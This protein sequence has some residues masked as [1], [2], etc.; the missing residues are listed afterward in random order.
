MPISVTSYSFFLF[1]F[2]Y[3]SNHGGHSPVLSCLCL[4]CTN[5]RFTPRRP[6]P[7]FRVLAASSPPR[8]S[9]R[10]SLSTNRSV[11]TA[12]ARRLSFVC[13]GH[14]T[15]H[16]LTTT[17]TTTTVAS[18]GATRGGA[19][20]TVAGDD[21]DVPDFDDLLDEVDEASDEADHAK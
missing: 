11:R 6:L 15:S 12:R 21:I 13:V 3:Y 10:P 7:A 14:R 2:L 8:A 9:D 19:P 5:G 4:V 17:T 16:Q 18:P 1:F 20:A